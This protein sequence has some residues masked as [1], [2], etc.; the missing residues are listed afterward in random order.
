MERRG[1][2]QSDPLGHGDRDER[3][4][5][6]RRLEGFLTNVIDFFTVWIEVV[7]LWPCHYYCTL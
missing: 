7:D 1:V 3:L 2:D 4:V 6:T 5:Q